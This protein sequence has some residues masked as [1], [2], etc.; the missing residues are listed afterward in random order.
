M[1][2]PPG[3]VD[4]IPWA[5]A[6][7]TARVYGPSMSIIR[8][9]QRELYAHVR[10]YAL[11]AAMVGVAIVALATRIDVEDV[12]AARF[13]PDRWWLWALT[14]LACGSLVGRRRWPLRTFASGLVLVLP[15]ELARQRDTVSFFALVIA[16]YSVAA[17]LPP[18]LARRGLA[19]AAAMYVVL[20]VSGVIV[21]SAVPV[22]GPLF[23]VSAFALG[24]II[25]RSRA[26]Q[27][28]RR[29][30]RHRPRGRRDRKRRAGRGR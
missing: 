3:Y 21:L 19:M 26:R 9:V 18:R 1:G 4:L 20:G 27:R 8:T 28:A 6:A 25:Q 15:L 30:G 10:D 14:I 24:L 29:P 7:T 12:D 22:L 13:E 16:L 11:A 23:L 5:D 2:R 17:Y